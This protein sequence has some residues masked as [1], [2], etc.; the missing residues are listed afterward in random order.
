MFAIYSFYIFSLL[1]SPFYKFNDT[2]RNPWFCLNTKSSLLSFFDRICLSI[3][4]TFLSSI[5]KEYIGSPFSMDIT[6]G[7][8]IFIISATKL[9]LSKFFKFL[10]KRLWFFGG[11]QSLGI[12]KNWG[13]WSEM[14]KVKF[15]D[16]PCK[17]LGAF[18]KILSI[19]VFECDVILVG[20]VMWG[21]YSNHLC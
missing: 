6:S 21:Y 19:R 15:P 7:Q 11:W 13:K 3:P 5:S 16:T 2:R 12:N 1:V 9:A 8:F 20:R 10:L 4:Q 17:K 14:E 18:E